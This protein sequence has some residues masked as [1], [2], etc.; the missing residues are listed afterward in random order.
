[1]V[2]YRQVAKGQSLDTIR[3][4][5]E[6]IVAAD[7]NEEIAR[8]DIKFIRTENNR[9]MYDT[10]VLESL[11]IPPLDGFDFIGISD[12]DNLVALINSEPGHPKEIRVLTP[13][14]EKG[15]WGLFFK[16]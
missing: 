7:V 6:E 3:K 8:Y 11:C 12:L 9:S 2:D 5:V 4:Q 16:D 15:G 14:S 10:Y 13:R 1:M